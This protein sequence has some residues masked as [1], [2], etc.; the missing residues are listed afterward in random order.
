EEHILAAVGNAA[1]AAAGERSI[2]LVAE[3]EPQETK[4]IRP[5]SEGGYGL[6]GLWNDDFHHSAIVALTGRQPTYYT[7]Y[8]GTPQEFI[9][10]VKYGFLYQGQRYTWQKMRRG[11]SSRGLGPEAFVGF[12]ENHDQVANSAEGERVRLTTSPGCHRALLTL[13][14]LGPWTPML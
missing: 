11:T 2:F 4:L 14:L 6:D 10:A 7:D 13:L 3:N 12:I 1:R 5:R 9:S 8:R